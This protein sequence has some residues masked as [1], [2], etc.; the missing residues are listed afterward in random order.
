[1]KDPAINQITATLSENRVTAAAVSPDGS[2]LAYSE[3][4][5]SLIIQDLKSGGRRLLRAPERT[6]IETISWIGSSGKILIS[7]ET[8][9]EVPTLWTEDLSDSQLYTLRQDARRGIASPDGQLIAF[10]SVDETEIWTMKADGGDVRKLVAGVV[11]DTFPFMAFSSDNRRVSY[12]RRHCRQYVYRELDPVRGRGKELARTAWTPSLL[13]DW[14]L[15]AA[16]AEAAMPN[17]DPRQ[18]RILLIA[19]DASPG[20]APATRELQVPELGGLLKLVAAD[21]NDNGWFASATSLQGVKLLHIDRNGRFRV[22]RE[23][24]ITTWEVPSPDGRRLAFVDQAAFSNF[25]SV[26]LF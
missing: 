13:G 22:L 20:H 19:L 17:H 7:G 23:C 2:R 18:A 11:V 16:G 10:T 15:S 1:M 26:G 14:T 5:G 3:F 25:W 24:P 8:E 21:A 4:G 6:L 9:A 12:Q